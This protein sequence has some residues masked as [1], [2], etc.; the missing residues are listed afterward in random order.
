MSS[1]FYGFMNIVV[2][3]TFVVHKS[4]G[5]R[6]RLCVCVHFIHD[7]LFPSICLLR[8]R[9]IFPCNRFIYHRTEFGSEFGNVFLNENNENDNPSNH[10][11]CE[12]A[13]RIYSKYVLDSKRHL[14]MNI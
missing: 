11:I 8:I 6:L 3:A 1:Y 5:V 13:Y 10:S 9:P 14:K 12:S 7:S 4:V 2:R